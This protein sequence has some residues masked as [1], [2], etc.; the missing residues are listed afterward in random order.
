MLNYN[1]P[2]SKAVIFGS[3]DISYA[4]NVR[5]A[6]II[7]GSKSSKFGFGFTI[8]KITLDITHRAGAVNPANTRLRLISHGKRTK[9]L[10][11]YLMITTHSSFHLILLLT[12]TTA[13]E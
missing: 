1:P 7:N 9:P 8:K 4:G 13:L 3:Y 5:G 10:L 2:K 12:N 6:F 11:V